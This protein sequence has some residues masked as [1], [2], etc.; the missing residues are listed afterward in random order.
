VDADDDIATLG[1][2]LPTIG[3]DRPTPVL[4]PEAY[5]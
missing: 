5:D 3:G 4:L 1:I 2:A